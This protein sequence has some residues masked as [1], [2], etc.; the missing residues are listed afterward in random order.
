M[1]TCPI[2]NNEKI[3]KVNSIVNNIEGYFLVVKGERCTSC[4]EEFIGEKEGQQMINR[5]KSFGI[6]GKF[7]QK[8][9]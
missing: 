2:C 7:S 4:N 1:K 8:I 9:H 5:A 3:I 6:W